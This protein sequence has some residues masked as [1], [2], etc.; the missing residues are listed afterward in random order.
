MLKYL[1]ARSRG[2]TVEMIMIEEKAAALPR[3]SLTTPWYISTVI[4]D[5]EGERSTSV[6]LSSEMIV[7]HDRIAPETIPPIIRR[8]VTL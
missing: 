3:S 1:V 5:Q 7:T 6:E 4:V 8:K 2:I